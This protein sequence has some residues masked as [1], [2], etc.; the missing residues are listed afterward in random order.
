[1]KCN[2]WAILI[3]LVMLSSCVGDDF[4]F[5]EVEPEIRITQIVDTL[6]VGDTYQLEATFLNNIGQPEQVE[7]D[8]ASSNDAIAAIDQNGLVE[9]IQEGVV[10]ITATTSNNSVEVSTSNNLVVGEHTVVGG[11]SV[12]SGTLRSTSSY[13]LKGDFELSDESGELILSLSENYAT[14]DVLPGLFVYLANNPNTINGALEIAEVVVFEGEHFYTLP[15]SVS[16]GD[17]AYVLYYCKPF[18]VKVGDGKFDE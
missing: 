8:W 12:R 15:N 11:E 14:D 2:G 18:R 1:M 16:I 13:R 4:I 9:G 6:G 17:F 10:Q 7:V 3:L 5:D